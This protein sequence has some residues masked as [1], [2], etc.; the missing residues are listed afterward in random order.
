MTVQ[1]Y[2]TQAGRINEVKG[3]MIAHAV[4]FEVLA[5]GCKMMPFPK[6]KGDNVT[7][8]RVLPYGG[9]A[10]NANTINR[11]SVN[12]TAHQVA[13]GVTPTA[14]TITYNDVSVTLSQY[15]CL[16]SYTDKAAMLYEDDIPGD[17]IQ[18]CGERMGL[19]REMIRY[20]SLKG[21]TNSYY[22]GGTTRPTVDETVSLN[23]LRHIA[24]NLL[25]NGASMKTRIL[26]PSPDYDTSAVE[27]GFVVFC[28]TDCEPDIRDLQG[29]VPVAKY[30]NR[31][32]IN[33]NEI[34]TVERF[35]FVLSK[36]LAPYA[37]SGA[38]KGSTGLFS[39]TGSNLDVYPMIVMGEE[40]AFDIALRGENSVDPYHIPHT[41]R[42][43]SDPGGQRGYVGCFFWSAVLVANNGWL[44]VAEVA[45]TD[46]TPA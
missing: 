26:A 12:A 4:P 39:T 32:P 40:G 29:F 28:H 9:A 43:K 17:M 1:A 19:V 16:Y 30:A 35:R 33:E 18:Q 6:N 20:G 7:Y 10:T 27:A 11:W 46:T 42:D 2:S 45:V 15:G 22:A 8:R 13:E 5:L 25:A 38:A 37:D 31:A 44:A 3:E 23:L 21:A 24:K 41:Q 14:D 34:G 36:E